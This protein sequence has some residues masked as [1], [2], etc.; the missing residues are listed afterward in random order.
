MCTMPLI[1]DMIGGTIVL[2]TLV[3]IGVGG[4]WRNYQVFVAVNEY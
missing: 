2:S 1:H 3:G 4:E